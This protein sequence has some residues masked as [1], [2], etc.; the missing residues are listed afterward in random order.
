ML[1]NDYFRIDNLT[2]NDVGF[3]TVNVC[4]IIPESGLENHCSN[5]SLNML[6]KGE[7]FPFD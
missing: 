1:F 5:T 2:E 3:N 6:L 7:V 4:L